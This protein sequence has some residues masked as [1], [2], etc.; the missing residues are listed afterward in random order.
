MPHVQFNAQV[1]DTT[2]GIVWYVCCPGFDSLYVA[3]H[4]SVQ[5][6]ASEKN[7]AK[8][9]TKLR[10]VYVALLLGTMVFQVAMTFWAKSF[11]TWFIAGALCQN[12]LNYVCYSF[13]LRNTALGYPPSSY[14]YVQDILYINVVVQVLSSFHIAF[15]YIYLIIPLYALYRVTCLLMT[16]NFF[17]N[18]GTVPTTTTTR[19]PSNKKSFRTR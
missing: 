13:I 3:Y 14:S 17:S 10:R 9:Y 6:R 19:T 5:A 18:P 1:V 8:K 12:L 11:T 4:S 2:C 15:A 7:T 16:S